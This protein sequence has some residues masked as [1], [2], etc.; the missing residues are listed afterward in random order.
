MVMSPPSAITTTAEKILLILR[1]SPQDWL[2]RSGIA[3]R[4]GRKRLNPFDLAAIQLLL[5]R[6]QIEARKEKEVPGIIGFAYEYR[7]KE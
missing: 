7:I 1:Q 3:S 4:L 6:G 5:E 2:S